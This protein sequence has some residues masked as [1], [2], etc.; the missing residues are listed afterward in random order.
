VRRLNRNIKLRSNDF[1]AYNI[2]SYIKDAKVDAKLRRRI[3]LTRKFIFDRNLE[4]I[5]K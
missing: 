5:N 2:I 1:G 3:K 4:E